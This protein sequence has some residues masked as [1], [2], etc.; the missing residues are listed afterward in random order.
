MK[1]KVKFI[2]KGLFMTIP[3]FDIQ[4]FVAVLIGNKVEENRDLFQNGGKLMCCWDSAMVKYLYTK[5][6]NLYWE[7]CK[8]VYLIN[9]RYQTD[10]SVNISV[11]QKK[12]FQLPELQTTIIEFL[13]DMEQLILGLE[14]K[15]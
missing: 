13:F 11:S 10:Q 12:I 5:V 15:G 8:W 6:E 9:K 14:Y 2:Y 4:Y 7:T 3:F 1:L